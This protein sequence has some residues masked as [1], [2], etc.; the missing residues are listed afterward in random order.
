[1]GIE[2][3]QK[4]SNHVASN[5]QLVLRVYEKAITVMWAAREKMLEDNSLEFLTDLHLVRQL[6]TEL[7]SCLDYEE[8]GEITTQLHQLYVFILTELSASGFEKSVERLENAISVAEQLYEGFFGA[9]SPDK[10]GL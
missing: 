7:V 9:F 8:G 6:F 5:E 3:Y 1:M 10:E 4:S 2:D